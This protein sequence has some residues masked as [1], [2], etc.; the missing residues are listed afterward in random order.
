MTGNNPSKA[1]RLNLGAL[2]GFFMRIEVTPQIEVIEG[3][4]YL[5]YFVYQT[6]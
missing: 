2:G 5:R 4:F 1:C 3:W 6:G